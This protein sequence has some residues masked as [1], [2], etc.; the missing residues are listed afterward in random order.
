MTELLSPMKWHQ[1]VTSNETKTTRVTSTLKSFF[2]IKFFENGVAYVTNS[3][4]V[5]DLIGVT[6][7]SH[8]KRQKPRLKF[9][10]KKPVVTERANETLRDCC[11][12]AEF[13][14]THFP[15]EFRPESL[16]IG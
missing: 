7:G 2:F 8:D 4:N 5:E 15:G 3:L 13:H 1:Q 10:G 9:V 12:N 14:V 16:V 6:R 11:R